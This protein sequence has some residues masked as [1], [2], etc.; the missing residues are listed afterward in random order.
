MNVGIPTALL[1]I[2]GNNIG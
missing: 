1:D 2:H